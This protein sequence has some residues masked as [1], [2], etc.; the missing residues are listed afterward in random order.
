MEPSYKPPRVRGFIYLCEAL[1]SAEP[2][3]CAAYAIHV[4][5][6]IPDRFP[7][8]QY[9]KPSSRLTPDRR[10]AIS[11]SSAILS[12]LSLN[13]SCRGS[14][15]KS[16]CYGRRARQT[17]REAWLD[18]QTIAEAAPR[19]SLRPPRFERDSDIREATRA[20][21]RHMIEFLVAEYGL[22]RENAYILC[23]VAGD[24]RMHE[25]VDM[26]NYVIGMMMPKS[27]FTKNK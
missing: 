2:V 23:S 11:G 14:K 9:S 4:P 12:A 1:R 3:I 21:V 24:L 8:F 13:Q 5:L 7:A 17:K 22:T 20:A 25:V 18:L 27:I 15:E 10:W 26:P 19:Q 16:E 6:L